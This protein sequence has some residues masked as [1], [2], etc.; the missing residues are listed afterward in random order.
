MTTS[1]VFP[2]VEDLPPVKYSCRDRPPIHREHSID[3]ELVRAQRESLNALVLTGVK[4]LPFSADVLALTIE[5]AEKGFMTHPVPI[6][7]LTL[8]RST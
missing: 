4:E 3:V 7:D 1:W 5:D 2:L 6:H 8:P